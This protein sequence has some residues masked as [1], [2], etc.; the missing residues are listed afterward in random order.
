MKLIASAILL[1]TFSVFSFGQQNIGVAAHNFSAV[2]INGDNLELNQL[3]GKVAVLTFWSTRCMICVAE[4]PKLN[5]LVE[6]YNRQNVEF[7]G[8][9]MNNESMVQSF[10][11][12]KTVKLTIIPNSLGVVLKY[13]DRDSQGRLLMGYPA[14]YIVDQKG[15]V[16]LKTS[17]W[18]QTTKIERTVDRLLQS[19]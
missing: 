12:K 6:K 13:A 16:T 2:T 8:L 11:K 1:L 5:K 7:I 17:G 9:T 19:E 14:Y 18:D 15:D 4:M 3:K 10:L